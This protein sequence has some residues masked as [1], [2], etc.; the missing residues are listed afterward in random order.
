MNDVMRRNAPNPLPNPLIDPITLEV[1]RNGLESIAD[2][3]GAVLKRTAFSPYRAGV[4]AIGA[5]PLRAL[6]ATRRRRRQARP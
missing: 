3:M 4:A 2:E 6:R 5:P 1:L